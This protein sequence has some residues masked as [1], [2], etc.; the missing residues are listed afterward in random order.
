MLARLISALDTSFVTAARLIEEHRATVVFITTIL[1]AREIKLA[2]AARLAGWKVVLIYSDN[3]PFVPKDEFDVVIRA[4]GPAEMHGMV[5]TLQPRLCHVFSGAIDDVVA[6]FVAEKPSPVIVDLNDVFVGSL[7]NYCE[8]RFEPTRRVLTQAD[9]VCARDLQM[10]VAQRFDDV[11]LPAHRLL[12]P[13]YCWIDGPAQPTAKPKLDG[14]EVHVVSVGSFTFE[15]DNMFDSA[16]LTLARLLVEQGIHFHIYPHW[17]YRFG[18][19]RSMRRNFHRD[20][21]PFIALA[22][23][24]PFLHLHKSLSLEKLA[25]EL[26]QYDFGIIAGG[27]AALGQKLSLLTERYMDC[28]YSGRIADYLDAR[29]PILINKEVS[30]N[31][32]LLRHYGIM[33]DLDDL[34]RPGFRDH[35]LRIKHDPAMT[36]RV[37]SAADHLSLE[38]N[39]GRLAAFYERVARDRTPGGMRSPRLQQLTK[40]PVVGRHFA[41]FQNRMNTLNRDLMQAHGELAA[42]RE[43][44]RQREL[45]LGRWMPA[46]RDHLAR[47]H[48]LAGTDGPGFPADPA[49]YSELVGLLNWPEIV[50]PA[51]RSNDFNA[52]L[53][54]FLTFMSRPT[55]LNTYSNSWRILAWKNVDD[56]LRHGFNSF[57]RTAGANYFNFF[58]QEGD[59][60]LLAVRAQLLPA[61]LNLCEQIAAGRPP[62][63]DF[64]IADQGA[65]W[66][67]VAALW[68]F[69]RG[70]DRLGLTRVLRE[71]PLGRPLT[72]QVEDAV[73]S[74]DLANSIIE[75]YAMAEHV[76]FDRVGHVMEIGAGYGRNAYVIM[77]L[78]PDVQYFIVDIPPTLYISQR[79]L[80]AIFA[81][82]KIFYFRDFTSYQEVRSE[83]ESSKIIFLMPHQLEML[84]NKMIGHAL[85]IS[86]FGEMTTDQVQRYFYQVDRVTR[87]TFYLKQWKVSINPFDGLHYREEDYPLRR[88]W[89][90]VFHRPC[91][92]QTAFFEG[93]Y[94]I[95]AP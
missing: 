39:A 22:K 56:L 93:L 61:D 45:E 41:S 26:P 83:I 70:R 76:D 21:G 75:Y 94:G 8:E 49:W 47:R 23:R 51:E 42:V 63:P 79:Y 3:T 43:R 9:G 4:P 55:E 20:F 85:S 34:T 80:S 27:S 59:P 52:L 66:Y 11:Q 77:T 60:Q 33:V 1:R 15:V 54:M 13:E 74:Q 58:I 53:F 78:H 73:V 29:L 36:N 67:F 46:A 57:K 32:R 81:D 90:R 14:D 18:S 95:D 25:K 65:Y 6:R 64:D 50:K 44:L 91:P 5:M 38:R 2:R 30:Y 88:N 89:R 37:G 48:L 82:R 17:A 69:I 86:S 68:Q 12:F 10:K 92:I 19:A 40:L 31:Y 87:N 62:E 71:P 7:F 72:L 24:S 16:Y 28:C 84:P 35:L